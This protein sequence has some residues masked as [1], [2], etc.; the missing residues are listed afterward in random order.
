MGI[1]EAAFKQMDDE[2]KA[3]VQDAADFAQSSP[4]P[5]EAE[6]WTDVLVEG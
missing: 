6:L 4:E 1:E 5:D 3:I 2:V